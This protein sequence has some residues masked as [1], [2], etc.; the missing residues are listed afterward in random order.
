MPSDSQDR[1]M[2]HTSAP[3]LSSGAGSLHAMLQEVSVAVRHAGGRRGGIIDCTSRSNRAVDR[4]KTRG[5]VEGQSSGDSADSHPC[6]GG[7][8]RSVRPQFE[9]AGVG[10]T[11][12]PISEPRPSRGHAVFVTSEVA[13]DRSF[14]RSPRLRHW[15]LC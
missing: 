10:S 9:A 13:S 5:A 11:S 8:R 14:F 7:P 2:L 4:D 12:R 3:V 1:Q 15:G 6:G